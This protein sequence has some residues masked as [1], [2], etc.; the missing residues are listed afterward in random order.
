MM[1][2]AFRASILFALATSVASCATIAT[3]EEYGDY[4]A[5]RTARDD[6]ARL[7]AMQRYVENHPDGYW[8]TDIQAERSEREEALWAES[9]DTHEGLEWYLRVYPDGEYVEQAR[10]RLAA[11]QTVSSRRREEA[12]RQEDLEEERRRQLAEQRR[13]WVTR[14]V[15]FWTGNLLGIRNYGASIQR[16]AQGNREFSDAFGQE[17]RP[18]CTRDYCIKHYGQLYHIPVPGS[19]RID[20]HIDVYL[21]LQLRAGR[22]ERAELLLPNKGFSRWYELENQT[23][24]TDEDP[25]QRM[26]AINWALERIQPIIE[27]AASGAQ[28]IDFVPE[29]LEPLQVQQDSR[30][31][32]VAPVAPGE[33]A[34]A[35]PASSESPP[36]PQQGAAPPAGGGDDSGIDALLREA[37]G[38]APEEAPARQAT[39]TPPPATPEPETLVLPINLMAFSH[40]NLRV[41][42]FAAAD[43]DYELGYDGIF[44]ERVR[45]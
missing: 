36:A 17:P 27:Q 22:V 21:R 7:V 41:V 10:Q 24:V 35:E 37:A 40:R 44:L 25:Q 12:E 13:T 30:N 14:A 15:Q 38:G 19:T 28:P 1:R 34:P 23:V 2:R 33:Q 32:E 43:N 4:R 18:T 5:V 29:P 20:R 11:L 45:D 6:R 3:H 9:S 39:P 8:V 31:T 16:V 42:V 26:E